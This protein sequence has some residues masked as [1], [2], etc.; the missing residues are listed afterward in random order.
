[1]PKDVEVA[2]G[3]GDTDSHAA[4]TRFKCVKT[5]I[6]EAITVE[7]AIQRTTTK[8]TEARDL[9]KRATSM[10]GP[11]PRDDLLEVENMVRDLTNTTHL[12]GNVD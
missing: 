9:A 3:R 1:M 8:A 5:L 2:E 6:P 11:F 10:S 7:P 12:I 4:L